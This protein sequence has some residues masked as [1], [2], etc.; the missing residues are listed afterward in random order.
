MS[1]LQ[2]ISF[3][4]KYIPSLQLIIVNYSLVAIPIKMIFKYKYNDE[5]LKYIY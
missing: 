5:E 2:K 3:Y 4:A 1:I